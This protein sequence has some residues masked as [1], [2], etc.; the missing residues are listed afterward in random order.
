[1][2]GDQSTGKSS[3]LQAVTD[4]PFQIQDGMCTRFA[5]EIELK[6]SA[7][8]EIDV[9]IIPDKSESLKRQE[10]MRSWRPDGFSKSGSLDKETMR[11]FFQQVCLTPLPNLRNRITSGRQRI[12]LS[13]K[14]MRSKSILIA[15][16]FVLLDL[17]RW[18]QI[19]RSLIFLDSFAV[20]LINSHS[21]WLKLNKD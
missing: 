3:V 14:R 9:K 21:R 20:R 13:E 17:D 8:T 10:A 12:S 18:K 15:R 4:I 2:V 6:R 1:M 11:S 19:S 5:T 16:P 7:T